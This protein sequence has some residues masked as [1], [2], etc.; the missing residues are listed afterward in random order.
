MYVAFAYCCMNEF[1]LLLLSS[2]AMKEAI[3]YMKGPEQ[4]CKMFDVE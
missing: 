1:C 2:N 4:K 3:W